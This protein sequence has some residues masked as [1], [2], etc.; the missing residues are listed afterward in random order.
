M[1]DIT[2]TWDPVNNRGDWT[3]VNGDLVTGSD[4]ETCVLICLFTDRV[5][6]TDMAPPDG[7]D[8]HRGWAGDTYETFPIGSRLWTLRRRS[9]SNVA[10]ILSDARDI[11]NEALAPLV[12]DGVA[13]SINVQTFYLGQ[14]QIGITVQI[15]EPNGNT[16]VFKYSWAWNGVT[17]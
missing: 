12:S 6:P 3:I 10:S 15:V 11:C 9:I 13:A 17:S 7:S 14:G 1:P 5:L 4:L 2:I 16:T 8:D